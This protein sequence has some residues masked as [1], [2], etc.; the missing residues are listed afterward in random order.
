MKFPC[1]VT[2]RILLAASMFLASAHF[3]QAQAMEPQPG[4]AMEH[5]MPHPGQHDGPMN[6]DNPVPPFLH[7]IELTEA[8]QDRIFDIMHS[9]APQMRERAKAI[10]KAHKELHALVMS[11]NYDDAKAR[12]LIDSLSRASTDMMLQH[13]RTDHQI[14]ALLTPEQ[15]KQLDERKDRHPMHP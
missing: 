9:Q 15:R 12:T 14:Y 10:G 11:P 2:S 4:P 5:G 7:G 1:L 13:V 8:Q 6:H 3:A